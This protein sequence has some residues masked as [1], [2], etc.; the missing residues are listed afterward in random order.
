MRRG[1]RRG[2]PSPPRA[3]LPPARGGYCAEGGVGA[4]VS[5]KNRGGGLA[6]VAGRAASP[7]PPARGHGP[8]PEE[9]AAYH[10]DANMY[11]ALLVPYGVAKRIDTAP[12][13]VVLAL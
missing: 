13:P 7:P 2:Y 12:P 5:G 8:T 3:S 9:I 10:R 4:T 6:R 1:A 11:F